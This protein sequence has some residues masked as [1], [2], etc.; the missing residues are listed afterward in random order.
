MAPVPNPPP[1][2]VTAAF[3]GRRV[4]LTGA[5]GFVGK[6]WLA[7]AIAHLPGLRRLDVLLRGRGDTTPRERFTAM[8]DGHPVFQALREQL[9]ED[10]LRTRLEQVHVVDGDVAQ[11]H[12]GLSEPHLEAFRRDTDLLLHCAGQVDFFPPVDETIRCNIDGALHAADL[13]ASS[14][15]A[16]LLHV[17]T[18]Y[19]A[20][21]RTGFQPEA[22]VR[23]H[24]LDGRTV[25]LDAHL[26]EI[27]DRLGLLRLLFESPMGREHVAERLRR[28]ARLKG[29]S[30]P[31]E[32][33]EEWER[34]RRDEFRKALIAEGHRI[35][36]EMQHPNPY[37]WSKWIGE[38]LVDRALPPERRC[39]FRPA[40]VESARRF[41]MPGWNEGFN[42]SGPL[43]VLIGTAYRYLPARPD[44]PFDV[45]PVD[46]V[47]RGMTIAS[48]ALLEGC[49][50]D[51]YQCGTSA[52]NRLTVGRACELTSLGHRIRRRQD[53]TP[54]ERLL[55]HVETL[56]APPD[57][58]LGLPRLRDALAW[59][60]DRM[61]RAADHLQAETGREGSLQQQ[62]R[63]AAK[64][65]ASA[66]NELRK[67]QRLVDVFAPFI[68][69]T[70]QVFETE[71]LRSHRVKDP[72]FRVDVTSIDWRHYWT[73]VHMP[74]LRRWC[75]DAAGT[76]FRDR[77]DAGTAPR[78]ENGAALPSTQE[79]A[80]RNGAHA[81]DPPSSG[82]AGNGAAPADVPPLP[83]ASPMRHDARTSAP[84]GP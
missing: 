39:T 45:I 50:A 14:D 55:S 70:P 71:A 43:I 13:I 19:V 76:G 51:I 27:R 37:T 69:D 67:I 21:N 63:R 60:T 66:A 26:Q 47:A 30:L 58:P 49:H 20:G 73:R 56:P 52:L 36:E 34:Q 68:H 9:G 31:E 64:R 35:A 72:H 75:L 59:A 16:R 24:T 5:T 3:E 74:G 29:L 65:S 38:L 57:H 62:L 12:F 4:L 7:L 28:R 8:V 83:A 81:H 82:A 48:A 40:I 79:K 10:T 2:D 61:Q 44:H 53:G 25:D 15:R 77:A 22:P 84:G 41:P 32:G 1:L 6:V 46:D 78:R 17:S 23:P 54:S 18:C 80:A 33:S 42:T 11:P